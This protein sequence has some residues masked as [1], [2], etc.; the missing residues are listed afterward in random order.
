MA[1][2]HLEVSTISRG[3]GQSVAKRTNYISG[4]RLRDSY[5]GKTYYDR[6]SDVL[7]FNVFL[8]R[9]APPNFHNLQTLC[10]EIERAERRYDARTAREFKGSLPN[11]LPPCELILIVRE[12]IEQNFMD[13][14]LC[15]IAAIHEGRNEADPSGDNPHVHI[16]VPT[17][18]V[19]TEGFCNRKYKEHDHRK[20]INIWRE[21]W[22][23]VQNRAYKRN[24][25]SIRVSH[26]S[27]AV[28]GVRSR[29]PTIHLSYADWQ[30][31]KRGEHTRSGG[32]KREITERNRERARQW[33]LE[34]ERTLERD[35][36]PKRERNR[37]RF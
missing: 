6:R 30:R 26:E 23:E 33:Q 29:E 17:R 15:A 35:L 1:N 10:D 8:P 28:Q 20:Y 14:G 11:E 7:Y 4:Q 34:Y 9:G 22:A 19:G 16:I 3:K 13:R 32:R 25:L 18:T 27:L 36:E 12:F 31:E 24:G 37:E 2:Y 5:T 21:Q